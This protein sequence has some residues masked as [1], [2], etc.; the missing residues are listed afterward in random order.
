M[1]PH[2]PIKIEVRGTGK[3]ENMS[4][5]R[6][7]I[8]IQL[9]TQAKR[10]LDQLCEQ[11]GMTQIAVLS[12]AVSWLTKQNDLIQTAILSGL[13]EADQAELAKLLLKRMSKTSDEGEGG[14]DR[15][16]S[17]STKRATRTF[18]NA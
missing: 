12:R 2:L 4:S 7:V 18:E 5:K 16:Q 3:V 14:E 6:A 10:L 1:F 9:D 17:R 8:R 13:S 11:R 15:V